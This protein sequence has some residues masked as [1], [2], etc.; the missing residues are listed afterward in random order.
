MSN[1]SSPCGRDDVE[2]VA[3]AD[4][5][6]DDAQAVRVRQGRAGRPA[7]A[8]CGPARAARWRLCRARSRSAMASR[9]RSPASCPPPCGVPRLPPRRR[10]RARRLRSTGTRRSPRTARRGGTGASATPHRSRAARTAPR[11]APGQRPMSAQLR[12]RARPRPSCRW[13]RARTAG[14]LRAARACDRRDLSP[15]RGARAAAAAGGP[16]R[17]SG[18][19][20]RGR[21]RESSSASRSRLASVGEQRR[22][23]GDRLLGATDVARRRGHRDQRLQLALGMCGDSLTGLGYELVHPGSLRHSR[24][25]SRAAGCC[26]RGRSGPARHRAWSFS[27][28][29]TADFVNWAPTRRA[30]SATASSTLFAARYERPLVIASHASATASSAAPSG[31]SCSVRPARIAAPVGP[32]VVDPDPRRPARDRACP[33]RSARP[34]RRAP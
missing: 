18:R 6:R 10:D 25:A 1:T 11:T 34:A 33:P 26:W 23:D 27:S 2:G 28:A 14:R 29:P 12:T 21:R 8:P 15:C 7:R 4:H 32:L 3:R 24:P 30:H 13:S 9:R 16:S 5:R 31:S 17:G 19:S 22:T 20:G